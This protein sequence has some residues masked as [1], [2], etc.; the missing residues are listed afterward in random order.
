MNDVEDADRQRVT[1]LLESGM[2]VREIAEE[3]GIGK[4]VVA[5]HEAAHRPRG[6][7]GGADRTR[8]NNPAKRCPLFP[9][10]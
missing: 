2:T 7:G 6:A 4:S 10:V 5:P 8:A 1:A 3:M 9:R